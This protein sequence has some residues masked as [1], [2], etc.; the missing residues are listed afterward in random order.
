MTAV[1]DASAAIEL[2]RKKEKAELIETYLLHS[3]LI[4]SSDLYKAECAN[5]IWK[6]AK[7]G[8]IKQ[9]EQNT[10][11]EQC[12]KLVYSFIDIRENCAES[13]FEATR[14]GHP[15]YDML[16]FTLARR[17]R[18]TLLTMDRRLTTICKENGIDCPLLN[19]I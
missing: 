9:E 7:A 15:V 3:N 10:L 18:A 17:T 2:I 16:Y 13:L 12:E 4:I 1:L 5:A 11:L 19:T 14:L 6:M 8:M